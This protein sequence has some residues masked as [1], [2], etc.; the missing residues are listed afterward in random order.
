[1]CMNY[2][3]MLPCLNLCLR[4]ATSHE[5]EVDKQCGCETFIAPELMNNNIAVS[6]E[7]YV[8]YN[9]CAAAYYI[10]MAFVL[11]AVKTWLRKKELVIAVILFLCMS[12][13]SLSMQLSMLILR[14]QYFPRTTLKMMMIGRLGLDFSK[15]SDAPGPLFQPLAVYGRWLYNMLLLCTSGTIKSVGVS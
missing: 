9:N 14:L 15:K 3:V 11:Y 10:A 8:T 13:S 2:P 5:F 12:S 6:R 1:M 4:C 7:M